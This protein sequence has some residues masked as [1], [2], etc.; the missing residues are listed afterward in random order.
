MV[1]YFWKAEILQST[2]CKIN[3]VFRV[4]KSGDFGR[5]GIFSDRRSLDVPCY[6]SPNTTKNYNSCGG[7]VWPYGSYIGLTITL[8]PPH[9]YNPR[10]W[11]QG[12]VILASYNTITWHINN[13]FYFEET[14]LSY[15][16]G[17]G[18]R[19]VFLYAIFCRKIYLLWLLA[20]KSMLNSGVTL[21]P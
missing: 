10:L 12:G 5:W 14:E 20:A 11:Q 3:F 15:C 8:T 4:K 16:G 18:R 17:K 1:L 13:L 6:C 19:V 21:N 2:R 7:F 9:L